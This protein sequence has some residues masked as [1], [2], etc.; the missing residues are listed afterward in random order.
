MSD[1]DSDSDEFS[2]STS[3]SNTGSD[4]S[5][6][7]SDFSSNEDEDFLVKSSSDWHNHS[8]NIVFALSGSGE[9]SA[10][11]DLSQPLAGSGST[12]RRG[13]EKGGGRSGSESMEKVGIKILFIQMEFCENSTLAD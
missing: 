5:T 7:G 2:D 1:S 6:S 12:P 4:S 10:P 13:G 9:T 3:E 8:S 11:Q